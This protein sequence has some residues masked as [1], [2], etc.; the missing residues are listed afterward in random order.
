MA[1]NKELKE[2]QLCH[3]M[4]PISSFYKRKDRN[5][6]Y[7]WK[8]SYCKE[9]CLQNVVET[10]KNNPEHYNE[11]NKEYLSQY[12]EENK[13]KYKIYYKRKMSKLNKMV[14]ATAKSSLHYRQ[15]KFFKPS[16]ALW[17]YKQEKVF[18]NAPE[19]HNLFI[20]AVS[21]L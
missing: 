8:T 15:R 12:Y 17:E 13:D 1:D 7:N 16:N 9:C 14:D 20:K 18:E 2:C 3:Q 6:G 21:C 4:L 11:Y 5:G 19:E 10:R